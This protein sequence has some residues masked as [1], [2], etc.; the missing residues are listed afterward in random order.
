MRKPNSS[1]KARRAAIARG[2]KRTDRAKRTKSER[3]LRN[4]KVK[5]EKAKSARQFQEYLNTLM[6]Q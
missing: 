3:N 6:P 2:K 4:E 5:M 1:V